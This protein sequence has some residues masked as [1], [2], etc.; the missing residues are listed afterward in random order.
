MDNS[1]LDNTMRT[2][3]P[4]IDTKKKQSFLNQ[5]MYKPNLKLLNT[6]GKKVINSWLI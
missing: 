5:L 3:N 1:Q 2:F 6:S 4:Y